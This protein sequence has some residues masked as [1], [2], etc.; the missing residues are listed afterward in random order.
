MRLTIARVLAVAGGLAAAAIVVWSAMPRPVPVETAVVTKGR[1]VATVDEDGKTRIRE[2][3]VVAAP[4]GGRLTRVRLKVGDPVNTDD[5]V[6]TIVPAP[7][8]FLDP[9]SR[10]E[11]EEK[12][13]AAEAAV[14]RATTLAQRARAQAEQSRRDLERTRRLS[15]RGVSTMQELERA[16]LAV[17]VADR[18]VRAA[19]FQ[20]HA[21]E[22]DLNQARALLAR[23]GDGAKGPAESWAVTAPVTG[24]VLKVTQESE[25][26]VQPSAP[27][28]EIGDAH[29]LEIVVDVLSRDAVEIQRDA[30]VMIEHWGGREAL[31][32]RVRRIEPAAFTKISTLGVEEQ[33][34]NVLVDITSAPE[35]WTNLGDGY[36]LDARIAVFSQDDASIVP[37]GALF[38]RGENWNVFVVNAGRVEAREI[39]LLRRSGRLAAVAAGLS[40]GERV[41]VY[42]SD[43]IAAGVRV[44]SR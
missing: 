17:Q 23:Y 43:R 5:V 26:I 20:K 3:Y 8:P 28:I 40:P 21:A 13:G 11:A 9:R 7:A 15:E 37:A 42:P 38:R 14:D 1:F 34:V 25:T 29:D 33:R 22:H 10:D 31:A 18:D 44:E 2:R 12:L 36:Q 19:E 27:I 16:E 41:I 6:A 4:L 35:R 30:E 24:L 39:T 32:G